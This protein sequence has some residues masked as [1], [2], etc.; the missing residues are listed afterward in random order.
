MAF[1]AQGH[2]TREWTYGMNEHR[3]LRGGRDPVA[4]ARVSVIIPPKSVVDDDLERIWKDGKGG[5]LDFRVGKGRE[6][7]GRRTRRRRMADD[8]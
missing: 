3:P 7:A 5:D 4:T 6:A 2:Q 8:H 1:T